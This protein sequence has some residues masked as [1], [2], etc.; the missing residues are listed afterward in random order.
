MTSHNT[1][2]APHR[3]EPAPFTGATASGDRVSVTLPALSV[4]VLEL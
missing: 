2:D 4:V 3:V 1:F